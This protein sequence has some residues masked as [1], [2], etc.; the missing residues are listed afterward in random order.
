M[1]IRLLRPRPKIV[2]EIQMNSTET[3]IE[4]WD[5]SYIEGWDITF[6]GTLD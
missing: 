5:G 6:E 3:M 1:M 4:F 2:K